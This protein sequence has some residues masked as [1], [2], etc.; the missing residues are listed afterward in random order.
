M[1]T[2]P[3]TVIAALILFVGLGGI[4]VAVPYAGAVTI[5]AGLLAAWHLFFRKDVPDQTQGRKRR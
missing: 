2:N 5:P 1:R 4:T 3:M